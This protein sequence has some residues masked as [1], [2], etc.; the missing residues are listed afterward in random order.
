MQCRH[1][2]IQSLHEAK[3]ATCRRVRVSMRNAITC[4]GRRDDVVRSPYGVVHLQLCGNRCTVSKSVCVYCWVL[5][6]GIKH[7]DCG[8]L[9]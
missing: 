5:G 2:R 9:M 4:L 1:S 7:H 3:G 6:E 8:L